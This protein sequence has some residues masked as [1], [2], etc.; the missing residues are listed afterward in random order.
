M[1][2]PLIPWQARACAI[3]I[4]YVVMF[5]LFLLGFGVGG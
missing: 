4:G 1:S 3:I 2:N 5:V